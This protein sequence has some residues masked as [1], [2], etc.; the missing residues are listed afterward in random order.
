[1]FWTL[2]FVVVS[3]TIS[4]L[5]L[6]WSRYITQQ[7]N[8]DRLQNVIREH[9]GATPPEHLVEK[10]IPMIRPHE[11]EDPQN[12][13]SSSSSEDVILSEHDVSAED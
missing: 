9:I 10:Y 12:H 4:H 1:M 2:F 7:T 11:E 6:E 13:M 5:W 8:H 3:V